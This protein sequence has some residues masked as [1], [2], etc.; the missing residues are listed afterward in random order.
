M[1][2]PQRAHWTAA[3]GLSSA[4]M[5]TAGLPHLRHANCTTDLAIEKGLG[6]GG[7]HR[8]PHG[9]GTLAAEGDRAWQGCIAADCEPER[10]RLNAELSPTV[11][12]AGGVRER[13]L[14]Q[15]QTF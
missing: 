11:S 15:A 2:W 6:A 13:Q 1:T 4:G 14:T 9:E 5:D 12:A 10:N 8:S 3:F 7:V